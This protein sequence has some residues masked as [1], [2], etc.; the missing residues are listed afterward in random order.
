[1]SATAPAAA[2]VIPHPYVDALACFREPIK[3]MADAGW[4]IDLYT[5]VTPSHPAPFFGRARVRLI[6]LE[7]TRTGTLRLLSQLIAR[8]PRYRWIV[9]VPQ[10][11]LYVSSIASRIAHVP[12]A[13]ISDELKVEAEAETEA[14]RRW[15]IRERRAHRRCR[16]TMALTEARADFIREENRLAAGH[17]MAIVPNA[18]PGPAR[19]LR[20]RYYHDALD[21]PDGARILLHAGSLWWGTA[22]ALIASAREWTFDAVVVFQGRL[23]SQA[24]GWRD[25]ARVRL[26]PGVLPAALLDHAVSS[27]S[28]GLAMY[29]TT[30]ANNRLM[31]A[32]SGKVCLYLKNRLPVIATRGSDLEWI[33]R[34][35]CG[36]CVASVAEIPA[37]AARI[38]GA[39][40]TYA[41][42][43]AR[44]FDRALEF[45]G[46]FRAVMNLLESA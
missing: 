25:S 2:F 14:Q 18:P 1:M 38:W 34:E 43:A 46:R 7:M 4:R 27:A 5:L 22:N 40:D 11:G 17:P 31:G 9:S 3:A 44:V 36:V 29:D 19:R 6:P 42:A 39:Y 41:D 32:A 13:C 28:I 21:L 45:N 37:A 8:R 15:K 33:E 16:W 26:A 23:P 24:E 35:G 20:S 12:I 10:W 30:I